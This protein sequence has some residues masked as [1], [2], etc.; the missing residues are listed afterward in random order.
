MREN[1][2]AEPPSTNEVSLCQKV[3]FARGILYQSIFLP[4]KKFFYFLKLLFVGK[5]LNKSG[6]EILL[7][8]PV[9]NVGKIACQTNEC[10]VFTEINNVENM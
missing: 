4:S 5:L 10:Q 7:L 3:F 9:K 2:K 1:E 6:K 8:N